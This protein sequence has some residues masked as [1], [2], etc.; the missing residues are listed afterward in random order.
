M[1]REVVSFC[2]GLAMTFRA[3]GPKQ[4]FWAV[5]IGDSVEFRMS[6]EEPKES[7]SAVTLKLKDIKEAYWDSNGKIRYRN[8]PKEIP[9]AVRIFEGGKVIET[10]SRYKVI[11]NGRYY[12]MPD[13]CREVP[14]EDMQSLMDLGVVN[15]RYRK[16]VQEALE[17]SAKRRRKAPTTKRTGS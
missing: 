4:R 5:S 11:Y 12:I 14:P 3:N 10:C 1:I 9:F 2:R 6:P 16:I 13:S 15:A 17:A 8:T 7:C